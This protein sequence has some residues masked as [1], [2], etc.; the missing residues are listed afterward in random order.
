MALASKSGILPRFSKMSGIQEWRNCVMLFVNIDGPDLRLPEHNCG[1]AE[2]NVVCVG[3]SG[4]D[5]VFELAQ[6]SSVAG[7]SLLLFTWFA[8]SR[9]SEDTPVVQRL[10]RSPRGGVP[11]SQLQRVGDDVQAS[12]RGRYA[13]A[14][15]AEQ[16]EQR[17]STEGANTLEQ[18]GDVTKVL[19]FCRRPGGRYVYCGRLGY[20]SHDPSVRPMRFRWQLLDWSHATDNVSLGGPVPSDPVVE[21]YTNA[22]AAAF[23]VDGGGAVRPPKRSGRVEHEAAAAVAAATTE[24]DSEIRGEGGGAAAEAEGRADGL[25]NQT[26]FLQLAGL[27]NL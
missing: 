3:T 26:L 16:A 20:H 25:C 5:N 17:S 1:S 4:Y 19:L 10:L 18:G 22:T 8:Q 6:S 27:V 21:Q 15:T 2:E 14:A 23:D 24:E 7:P 11:P 13:T 9:Q 12:S